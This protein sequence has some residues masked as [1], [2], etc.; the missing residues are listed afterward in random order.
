MTYNV[1]NTYT[2]A[3]LGQGYGICTTALNTL[4]KTATLSSYALVVGGII[5]IKFTYGV[6][7]NA[8]LNVNSK[9]AKNIFYRGIKIIDDVIKAGDIITFIYDGTQY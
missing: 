1:N 3:S 7:A 2:N 5:S 4:A 6:P 9:G 8:T